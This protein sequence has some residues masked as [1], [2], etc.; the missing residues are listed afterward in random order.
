[1]VKKKGNPKYKTITRYRGSEKGITTY[2]SY[3]PRKNTYQFKVDDGTN[4]TVMA[5][6]KDGA[7]KQANSWSKWVV[8]HLKKSYN[9]TIKR[10]KVK[11]HKLLYKG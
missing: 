5:F 7:V 11:Y 9:R 2:K 4:L 10:P 6:N 3:I 1:M 8:R